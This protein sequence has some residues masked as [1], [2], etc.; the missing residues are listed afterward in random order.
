MKTLQ[1]R[2]IKTEADGK[3]PCGQKSGFE[4]R[5]FRMP[6]NDCPNCVVELEFA[7]KDQKLFYCA[8]IMLLEQAPMPPLTSIQLGSSDDESSG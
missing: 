1:P 2:D 5:E 3:F 8:D 4:A 6:S 7:F